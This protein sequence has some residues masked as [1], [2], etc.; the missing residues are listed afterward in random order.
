LPQKKYPKLLSL[1]Q[2]EVPESGQLAFTLTFQ[3]AETPFKV[4]NEPERVR[5]YSKF[6]GPN[7]KASVEKVDS[8]KR[9]V[10]IKLVTTT[11][12]S[13]SLLYHMDIVL[14]CLRHIYRRNTKNYWLNHYQW[15]ILIL[16]RH[17]MQ[18]LSNL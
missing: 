11:T 6:F 4:W 7:V 9:I 12:V 14:I 17:Q 2:E 1:T 8:D 3:S 18:T 16:L 10:A 13:T 15:L 5:K